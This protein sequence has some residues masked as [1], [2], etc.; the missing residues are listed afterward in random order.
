MLPTKH[1]KLFCISILIWPMFLL[2]QGIRIPSGAYVIANSGNIV[3]NNNWT[4]NGKFTHNTGTIV[5]AGTRQQI[6]GTGISSF[7]NLLITTSSNTSIT[8]VGHS[9]KHI[10]KCD[11]ILNANN[12]FTL[13]ANATQTALVD[14][15]GIGDIV[16]NL[17]MQGYLSNGFG[18]KYLG[19]PFQLATV[20]EMSGEVNLAATFPSVYRHDE[21]QTS[22]GWISYTTAT[23]TLV[24]LRGYAFQLGNSI[25]ARTIDM[26]GVIN[27]KNLSLSLS[28]HNQ[29]FTKGFNL[30]SNPYPSPINWNAAAGWTKT[31]IDNALYFF[32]A[33][34]TDQYG[35]TYSSYINNVSSDGKANNIIP[36]MQGFF[37]HVSAGTFPVSGLLSISN[38]TRI[39]VMP[40]TYRHLNGMDSIS[41]LRLRANLSGNTESDP[42][43]IYFQNKASQKFDGDLDALKIMNTNAGI[44]SI[45]TISSDQQNLSINALSLPDSSL[46]I[47]LGVQ[48][49]KDG[50]LAF[51]ITDINALPTYLFCYLLDKTTGNYHEL[52]QNS[53]YTFDLAAG[54]YENRFSLVFSRKE[55][56]SAQISA[57]PTAVGFQIYGAGKNLQIILNI[58]TGQKADIRFIN[59][60]GQVLITKTYAQSGSY[61][62]NLQL[63]NGIYQVVCYTSDSIITKQIF[64]GN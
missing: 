17:T 31:N 16:G 19:S 20:N 35:G 6:N 22:N 42:T 54:I 52:K 47:P 9:L 30:V 61:P 58:P 45:Y 59:M 1:I 55:I 10:I 12:N 40:Q 53:R 11:G 60:A 49:M 44:P 24:P 51:F 13:L 18:Y 3:T 46:Q 34:T 63:P 29:T 5:F 57:E 28:N 8:S 62:L 37:V 56:L 36:A 26:N 2:A 50:E 41:L 38:P 48:M 64:I 27:N 15:T 43:V 25:G 7:Y 4:N 33:G 21:N 14:G 39:T 32:D 23:N